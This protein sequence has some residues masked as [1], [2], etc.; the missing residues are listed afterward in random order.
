MLFYF[1]HSFV[2]TSVF[3]SIWVFRVTGAARPRSVRIVRGL[4]ILICR[5][6]FEAAGL[7]FVCITGVFLLFYSSGLRLQPWPFFRSFKSIFGIIKII[8]VHI[9]VIDILGSG[10]EL[11]S[12]R[13]L[14]RCLG[15]AQVL[16]IRIIVPNV[17]PWLLYLIS[18]LAV[19][20]FKMILLC[21][22]VEGFWWGA[23]FVF[24][25]WVLYR[26]AFIWSNILGCI[27]CKI[28]GV[29]SLRPS[30][31]LWDFALLVGLFLFLLASFL[32]L[33]VLWQS[34]VD[35][36]FVKERDGFVQDI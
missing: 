31:L 18:E 21:L 23:Y 30:F 13:W 3:R 7:S 15:V 11:A 9:R 25:V 19:L 35:F 22:S 6:F 2:N 14:F 34:F 5:W 4:H 10:S 16:F 29:P 36:N 20:F 28:L 1:P 33:K 17:G 12:Y 24:L 8:I 26:L 32:V 27:F